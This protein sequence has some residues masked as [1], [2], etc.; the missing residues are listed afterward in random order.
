MTRASN[1]AMEKVT[2]SNIES[3][4]H[5]P[6]G[7]ELHVRFTNGST[8]VYA[9]VHRLYFQRMKEAASPGNFHAEHIKGV[10]K[11]RKL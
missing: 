4:G 10:F 11:H 6:H 3:I 9:D 2:S 5:D 1:I 7:S 8:Y